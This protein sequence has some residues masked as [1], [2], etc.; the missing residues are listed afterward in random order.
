MNYADV[1]LPLPLAG[2]FT[3]SVPNAIAADVAVGKRVAVQF[4]VRKKYSG[5]VIRVHD[6]A[7]AHDI[8]VKP[9][10][11]VIDTSSVVTTR[12]L[13]FWHWMAEYYMCTEGEVM[14]AALPAG[15]KLAGES[16]VGYNDDYDGNA[17]L[18]SREQAVA[19]FL[20]AEGEMS[21][22]MLERKSRQGNLVA[23]VRSLY[24]KGIVRMREELRG[25][26]RPRYETRVTLSA[27]C[28]NETQLAEIMD[29]M[30]RAPS[31]L[32]LLTEY[33]DMSAASTALTLK[34]AALLRPVSKRELLQRCGIN[35]A[36]LTE[37]RRKGVLETQK[38]EITR[39][40]STR[41]T[42]MPLHALSSAQQKAF[43][44]IT[45]TFRSKNVCLLHGIT[46]SGKTEIY[47]HL[48]YRAIAKG[49]NVLYML[50]E[51]ALT[52]QITQRLRLFFGNDMGVYHSKFPDSERTE[53]WQKQISSS[54]YKLII[55]VRSSLFLPQ[56]NL[57][58]IIVDE[59]HEPSYKQ[60]E[61][62]PRYN[63]RDAAIMLAEMCGAKV[64]LGT[65][66]PSLESYANAKSGKYGLVELT[67]RFGEVRL[68]E[69]RVEDVKELRRKKMMTT[70]LSPQL[71][72]EIRNAL[73]DGQQTILF[74]NRRGYA[75]FIDCH[76]CGWVPR[77]EHCDVSLTY[78][79][80]SDSLVCHYCGATYRVPRR[81]PVCGADTLDDCGFGTEK[82][83]STVHE[84]FPDARVARLDLDT[85]QT[86]SSYDKI[87]SG[88]RDGKTDILIGTQMVSKGLDFDNVRVVGILD[89]DTAV[90]FPDFRSQER[91]FQMMAQV[92]GRAGRR[93]AC[94]IVILQTRNPALPLIAHVVAN[95]YAAMYSTQISER[96]MFGF[97]PFCRLIYV[98]IRH[99][100]QAV[101]ECAA[102]EM[103]EVLSP[104]FGTSL[105]GPADPPVSRVR[106]LYIKQIMIKALRNV[107]VAAVRNILHSTATDIRKSRNVEVFFDVDPM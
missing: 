18:T 98:Y 51:I 26:Y 44:S 82:I 88:F 86:R 46:S 48:I 94:G 63:A 11:E 25:N 47:I 24:D 4:G 73:Q 38:A 56:Q 59:E 7:P 55:G 99:R 32:K 83:E 89:A 14:K 6:D 72:S 43:T 52:T 12:Q 102:R 97:P 19:D 3:Y 54:P 8:T 22:G 69:I 58:L 64:L 1:L 85:T 29:G 104:A 103:A 53:I 34:N 36:A 61:P 39:L 33:L 13:S 96:R 71:I 50:P 65:A 84:L 28:L 77:C 23:V 95:D 30:K 66:T 62:A 16:I 40:Q 92:A 70:P 75:P 5:I 49:Y 37:L 106:S 101:A 81:C 17:H 107:S 79:K 21:I 41:A 105:L 2:A 68:P 87:L 80:K 42:R 100:S 35:E 45:A 31:Q 93:N 9:I 57:G 10:L 76:A 20:A 91:A 74:H 78:H 27:S 90:N 60:T 67:E 15:M